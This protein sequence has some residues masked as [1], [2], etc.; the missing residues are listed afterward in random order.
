MKNSKSCLLIVGFCCYCFGVLGNLSLQA[1]CNPADEV[2]SWYSWAKDWENYAIDQFPIPESQEMII[3]DSIHVRMMEENAIV[4]GH[5]KQAYLEQILAKLT[6]HTQRK[7]ITYKIHV[8]NDRQ[9]LNAFSVAGGH[10]YITSKMIDWV[11][12]EDELAFI[13]AHEIAHV[14]TKHAIRKVQKLIL[15]ETF[16]GDYGILA[17]NLEILLSAPF[18]QIDEYEADRAGAVIAVEADYNP[19]L[20]L[21]FFEKMGEGEQYNTLEKIIRTHPYSQ[22]RHNCLDDYLRTQLG[23]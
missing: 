17:A 22:E 20:A 7:G 14:D 23:K 16:F 15:G 3:G 5:P 9:T 19:R 8:I 4:K 18:G 11:E 1:Q 10:L 13:L 2:E 12:T 21:R 6:P